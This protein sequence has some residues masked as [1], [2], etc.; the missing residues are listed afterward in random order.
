LTTATPRRSRRRIGTKGQHASSTRTKNSGA[1]AIQQQKPNKKKHNLPK[2]GVSPYAKKSSQ[3][4]KTK[5]MRDA[6]VYKVVTKGRCSRGRALYLFLSALTFVVNCRLKYPDLKSSKFKLKF[7]LSSTVSS[8]AKYFWFYPPKADD[9]LQLFLLKQ[10]QPTASWC[11]PN[12]FGTCRHTG[13][14]DTRKLRHFQVEVNNK[15]VIAEERER[16]GQGALY[17]H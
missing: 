16:G 3:G 14:F 9:S 6:V 1:R 5:K 10:L 2:T 11:S 13:K 15:K 12:V 7:K 17:P 4:T 8:E